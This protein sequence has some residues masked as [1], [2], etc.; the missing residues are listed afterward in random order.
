METRTPQ[1][2]QEQAFRRSLPP[3]RAQSVATEGCV[4]RQG[5]RKFPRLR[6]QRMHVHHIRSHGLFGVAPLRGVARALGV[7]A[8]R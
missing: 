1:E 6:I 5:R 4:V 2:R 8:F 7:S 3:P